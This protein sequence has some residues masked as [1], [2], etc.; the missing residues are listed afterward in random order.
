MRDTQ[1]AG[2]YLGL[3]VSGHGT[4]VQVQYTSTWCLSL[5]L[6]TE[7]VLSGSQSVGRS[8]T[9]LERKKM[10]PLASR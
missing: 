10:S 9:V 3:R 6:P 4:L 7:A 1:H 5:R 8:G 2:G